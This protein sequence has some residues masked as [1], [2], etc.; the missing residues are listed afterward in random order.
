M[1][2]DYCFR[3][4]PASGIKDHRS[5]I[6][7]QTIHYPASVIQDPVSSIQHHTSNQLLLITQSSIS[8]ALFPGLSNIMHFIKQRA[9]TTGSHLKSLLAHPIRPPSHPNL[10]PR[11]SYKGTMLN[12]PGLVSPLQLNPQVSGHA[13]KHPPPPTRAISRA[14]TKRPTY[15]KQIPDYGTSWLVYLIRNPKL[16]GHTFAA[17]PS[18]LQE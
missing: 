14:S 15:P 2:I 3:I 18:Q 4:H 6:H 10:E 11:L 16:Y 5:G 8:P 9:A 13:H 7:Y 17:H 1:R 12:I